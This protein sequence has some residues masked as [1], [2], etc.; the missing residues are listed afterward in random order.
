[1]EYLDDTASVGIEAS[2]IS[3]A[4]DST[5]EL[6]LRLLKDD[7]KRTRI[8][9]RG[10]KKVIEL[11]SK[12]S[13]MLKYL[14]LFLAEPKTKASPAYCCEEEV[15]APFRRPGGSLAAYLLVLQAG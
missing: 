12:K 5:V 4:I 2:P 11:Y 13:A 1:M 10:K 6:L 15:L 3:P 8:G 7:T 14:D 9:Q